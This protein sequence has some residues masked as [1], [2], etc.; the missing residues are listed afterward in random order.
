MFRGLYLGFMRLHI[1]YHA[2]HEA[3]YG[4]AMREELA[5]HGYDLS[6]GTLYPMLREM[7]QAGLLHREQRVVK[8]KVRMYYTATADGHQAIKDIRVKLRELSG[9]LLDGETPHL[10]GLDSWHEDEDASP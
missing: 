10:S 6:P 7:E 8:G 9:E 1:L 5:R 4:V 3:I 2:S